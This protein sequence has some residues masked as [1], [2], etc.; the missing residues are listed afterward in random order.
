MSPLDLSFQC[1]FKSLQVS[2]EL[3]SPVPA[4]S[5][6]FCSMASQTRLSMS[7]IFLSSQ[8][9]TPQRKS[10]PA[11]NGSMCCQLAGSDVAEMLRADIKY[12]EA[13]GIKIEPGCFCSPGSDQFTLLGS[14]DS[15]EIPNRLLLIDCRWPYEF[16]GGHIISAANY[17]DGQRLQEELVFGPNSPLSEDVDVIFYCQYS[18]VRAVKMSNFFWK[19]CQREP[20]SSLHVE[21]HILMGGFD[22]FY[23]RHRELTTGGY[24]REKE[25]GFL[26]L[27]DEYSRGG[28]YDMGVE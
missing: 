17:Y 20:L 15:D 21:T 26:R 4:I 12:C 8:C 13:N 27:S 14:P 22:Q 2:S 7:D 1:P 25:E 11:R 10:C 9:K 24:V 3:V 23:E 16:E 28:R 6:A 18:Q 5:T 19:L